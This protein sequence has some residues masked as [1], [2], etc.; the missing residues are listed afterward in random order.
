MEDKFRE[1]W[2]E[3]WF[4]YILKYNDGRWNW[5]ELSRNPNVSVHLMSAHVGFNWD[6]R[7]FY[8]V[9]LHSKMDTYKQ[10][11]YYDLLSLVN[12]KDITWEDIKNGQS[13]DYDWYEICK[14]PEIMNWKIFNTEFQYAWKRSAWSG[15]SENPSVTWEI[16]QKN[17]SSRWDWPHVSKNPNI[18]WK[19]VQEVPY[20]LWDWDALSEHPNITWEIIQDNPNQ[21]WNARNVSKNPNI[22]WKIVQ[23]NPSF[24]WHW[25]TLSAHSAITWENIQTNPSKPW[26]WP[27]VSLNPNISWEIVELNL[28][29]HWCWSQLQLNPMTRAKNQFIYEKMVKYYRKVLTDLFREQNMPEQVISEICANISL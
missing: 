25:P 11:H 8:M 18:S 20:Q 26:H 17:P 14:N 9:R 24:P 16:I 1:E 4:Q 2:E 5:R 10:H 12:S 28:D 3:H 27:S 7:N 22:T 6:L 29:K 23:E 19:N 13:S 15:I 21:S